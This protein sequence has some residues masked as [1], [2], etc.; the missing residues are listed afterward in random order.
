M[1]IVNPKSD[2]KEET[3]EEI[4]A[5]L[6]NMQSQLDGV[7]A[8]DFI[9]AAPAL[10]VEQTHPRLTE[11]L[12]ING[13]SYPGLWVPNYDAL[14]VGVRGANW[15]QCSSR[16][17]QGLHCTYD[18]ERCSGG[19]MHHA[20]AGRDSEFVG[21]EDADLDM[22]LEFWRSSEEG[23]SGYDLQ[24]YKEGVIIENRSPIRDFTPS[25]RKQYS[26]SD[27]CGKAS[28]TGLVCTMHPGHE[29]SHIA[30]NGSFIQQIWE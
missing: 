1:A 6:Q 7:S 14:M 24:L 25:Y 30:G 11:M 16:S 23:N 17:P 21:G 9:D 18:A 22:I 15:K 2:Q 12:V 8:G 26:S 4:L 5:R 19:W 29:Y 3:S 10:V 20:S 27:F 28:D 13:N